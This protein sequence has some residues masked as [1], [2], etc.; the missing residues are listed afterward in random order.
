MTHGEAW[1]VAKEN[2]E[3]K[4]GYYREPSGLPDRMSPKDAIKYYKAKIRDYF[5]S[6]LTVRD[7][8]KAEDYFGFFEAKKIK[9][10]VIWEY[11]RQNSLRV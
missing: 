10:G 2:A 9:Q 4:Y 11:T 1:F 5:D 6:K 8:D 7:F 3:W